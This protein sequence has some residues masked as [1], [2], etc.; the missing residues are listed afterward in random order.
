MTERMNKDDKEG[1]KALYTGFKELS[2]EEYHFL[3][4]KY[5]L[6]TGPRAIADKYM[7]KEYGMKE[8]DYRNKRLDIEEKLRENV[9]VKVKPVTTGK[10]IAEIINDVI[11][12][13]KE[14]YGEHFNSIELKK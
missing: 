2:E 4:E 13:N 9:I 5:Y 3:W 14:L 12:G 6:S 8:H 10:T 1:L 7:A 11:E